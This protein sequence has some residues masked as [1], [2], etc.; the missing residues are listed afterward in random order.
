[1]NSYIDSSYVL[2]ILFQEDSHK[3]ASLRLSR[4]SRIYS[5]ILLE[6]EVLSAIKRNGLNPEDADEIFS[7]V[8]FVDIS[9]RL[10]HEI[11]LTLQKGYAKGADTLHLATALSL[12]PTAKQI[13]FLT[14]DKTQ[15]KIAKQLGFVTS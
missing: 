6:A 2:A 9:K 1:M 4:S 15:T 7:M 12:D 13:A 8:S 11:K 14:L 5:S 3:A 10:S